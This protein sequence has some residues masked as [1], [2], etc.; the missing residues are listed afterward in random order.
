MNLPSLI[1]LYNAYPT[2]DIRFV[3]YGMHTTVFATEKTL[4][5]DP[6]HVSVIDNRIE[7]RT[8]CLKAVPINLAEGVGMYR[9]FKG[10][11]DSLWRA[12]KS[13]EEWMETC[14]EIPEGLPALKRRQYTV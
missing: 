13:F 6:Y 1:K 5:L 10:H 4:F 12:G 14:T 8:I 7:N 3:R 9:L 11:F 2:L